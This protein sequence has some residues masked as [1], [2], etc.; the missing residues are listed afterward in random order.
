MAAEW[1]G[2]G[3]AIAK[4]LLRAA[5]RSDAADALDDARIGWDGFLTARG[6]EN[7]LGK[8]I[9]RSWSSTWEVPRMRSKLICGRQP[10]MS[11]TY[12]AAWVKMIRR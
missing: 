5:D 2:L 7:A 8:I 3:L 9:A 10:K 4:M 1:L 6:N 11:P 12:L